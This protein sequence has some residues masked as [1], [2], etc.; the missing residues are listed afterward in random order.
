MRTWTTALL[1][2]LLP[3]AA[4]AGGMDKAAY[5][6]AFPPVQVDESEQT[7]LDRCLAAW[8]EHPFAENGPYTVRVISSNVRVMGVG[9]EVTD[10][11]ETDFPALILV[12]STVNVMTKTTYQL[13]NP[14]GWYCFDANVTVAGKNVMKHHCATHVA[15]ARGGKSIAASTTQDNMGTTV[16]GKL[17]VESVGDCSAVEQATPP[18]PA[19]TGESI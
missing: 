7:S 2:G 17:T 18:T 12:K 5:D 4:L 13:L 19:P 16:A 15:D 6:K 14:N 3:T 10:T 1:L 8:G 11:V 9:N